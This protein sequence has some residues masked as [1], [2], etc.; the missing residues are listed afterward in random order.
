MYNKA[1]DRS[2]ADQTLNVPINA[3]KTYIIAPALTRLSLG[4]QLAF[5]VIMAPTV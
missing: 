1:G 3:S 5:D 2:Q 4:G